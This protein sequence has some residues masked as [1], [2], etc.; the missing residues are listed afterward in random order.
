MRKLFTSLALAS[1]VVTGG[2]Q[3]ALTPGQRSAIVQSVDIGCDLLKTW[4]GGADGGA[5]RGWC[6]PAVTACRAV[7]AGLAAILPALFGSE[8][9]GVMTAAGLDGRATVATK[10]LVGPITPSCAEWGAWCAT[11]PAGAGELCAALEYGCREGVAVDTAIVAGPE[12]D[13]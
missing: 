12:G 8:S 6:G 9:G 13:R 7:G 4:C 3:C 10:N 1:A 11:S 5:P 2:V